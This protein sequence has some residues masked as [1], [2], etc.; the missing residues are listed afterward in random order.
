MRSTAGCL[1]L[2]ILLGICAEPA[3]CKPKVKVHLSK[4]TEELEREAFQVAL[5]AVTIYTIEN[6]MAKYIGK[7][8]ERKHGGTWQCVMGSSG[9]WVRYKSSYISFSVG[10]HKIALFNTA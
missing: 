8:F 2:I 4:M 5:V 10:E 1:I 7:E 3:L 6:D 9:Y